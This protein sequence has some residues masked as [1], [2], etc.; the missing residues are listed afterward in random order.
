MWYSSTQV[1]RLGSSTDV[2]GCAFVRL[3]FVSVR[4]V[5]L[6]GSLSNVGRFSET[7]TG[8]NVS[9]H[10]FLRKRGYSTWCM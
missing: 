4:T 10:F 8:D 5:A 3:S 7:R 6:A 1:N 9:N 2:V